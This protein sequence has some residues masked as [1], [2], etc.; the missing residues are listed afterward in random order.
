VFVTSDTQIGVGINWVFGLCPLSGISKNTTFQK[1]ICFH[2]Q[3]KGWETPT[4]LGLLE[5]S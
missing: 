5:R 3:V 1:L 4:L 2:F